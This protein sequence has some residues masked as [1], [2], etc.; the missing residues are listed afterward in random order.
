MNEE[1]HSLLANN[2][3]DLVHLIKGKKL[4]ICK[5]VYKTQ[6]GLDGKVD[7]HKAILV[8]KM[9]SIHLVLSL[10]AYYKWEDHQMDAK[11]SLL[12][13]E[14]HEEIYMNNLLV[15]IEMTLT[16]STTLRNLFT[17]FIKPIIFSI[18]KWIY[19]RYWI[20]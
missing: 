14:L 19:F 20:F 7:K 16:F 15:S 12:H 9:N 11:Y 17:V 8:A 10:V 2:T 3:L 5:W 4:V 1:Y 13:G 6:Y 18:L